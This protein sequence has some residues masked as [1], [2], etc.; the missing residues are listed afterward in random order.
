M[1]NIILTFVSVLV[2]VIAAALIVPSFIDWSQYRDEIKT[3]VEKNTGYRVELQGSLRAAFLPYPQVSIENVTIDSGHAKGA[4]AFSGQVDKASVSL[5]LI[6]LLSGKITVNDITLIKPVLTIKE[7]AVTPSETSETEPQAEGKTGSRAAD[8][9]TIAGVM[10]R[11]A[12]LTWKPIKGESQRVVIPS[13]DLSAETLFGPYGFKG[14]VLYN[15]MPF[16]FKGET[17]APYTKTA[18]FPLTIQVAGKGYNLSYS[19]I[20][21]MTDDIP[22][23]QG[24]TQIS[25]TDPKAFNIPVKDA[26]MLGGLLSASSKA[27]KLDNGIFAIGDMKGD[28]TLTAAGLDGETKT[29]DMAVVFANAVDLDRIMADVTKKTASSGATGNAAQAQAA[30]SRYDF[31]PETVELP[32]GLQANVTVKTPAVV[33]KARTVKDVQANAALRDNKVN[34]SAQF[35]SLPDGGQVTFKAMVAGESVSRDGAKGNYILLN[36]ALDFETM[37]DLKSLKILAADWLGAVDVKTFD[38]PSVPHSLSGQITGRVGRNTVRAS[39]SSLNA[40]DYKIKGLAVTYVNGVTP[41]FDV[42][43]ADLNG[44]S[45]AISGTATDTKSFQLAIKHP[46]AG[47]AIRIV[48]KDFTS[49]ATALQKPLSFKADVE[50]ADKVVTIRNMNTV[51]GAITTTGEVTVNT[52]LAKPSIKADIQFA[53]LDTRELLTGQKSAAATGGGAGNATANTNTSAPWSRDALDTGFLRSMNLDMTAKAQKLIHGGWV[54]DQP[55]IDIDMNDGVLT[56]NDIAGRLFGG[57]VSVKGRVSAQAAGQPL[58]INATID[59]QTVDLGALVKAATSQTKDRVNGTGSFAMA[60][61]TRGLSSSALVYGLNGDG[62]IKT[63]DLVIKGIDLAKISEAI[64]DESL[65][66]LAAVVRGAFSGGQTAF[67]PINHKLAIREGTMPVNDFRLV[68]DSGY[69]VSNGEVSFA[70][71]NMDVTSGIVLTKPEKLPEMTMTI[72]GPLNAPQQ[73]VAND[74]LM[75]FVKNKY[76]AKIQKQ[77]DKVL[78]DKLKDSPVGGVINNLLGLP[79][80]Q[81]PVEPDAAETPDQ[82]V[83]DKPQPQPSLE[84]QVIRGLFQKF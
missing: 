20:V 60:L 83:E 26:I 54:I 29:V 37:L 35:G 78:G 70:R 66:D 30:K 22:A 36:P 25:I 15:D 18:P 31:L 8:T 82:P 16:D 4:F 69:L 24:E 43:I 79:P 57:T 28:L 44:A 50:M 41:K 46:N 77:I 11:D 27:A 33:Y 61:K 56:V 12:D 53:T 34:A 68:S 1:K 67:E 80:K 17:G 21:D 75:S 81:Q 3:Q 45:V 5:A 58:D 19:G 42:S 39:A 55:A 32:A 40:G 62:T 71:W 47:N 9:I 59:A 63:G 14:S 72:K 64:S 51:L 10:L 73:N 2:L 7:Q 38:N 52:A 48:K 74:L 65:T 6:P 49:D 84:E 76:G 13:F 23:V